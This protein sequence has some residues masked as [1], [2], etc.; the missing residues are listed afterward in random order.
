MATF[1][2]NK[3]LAEAFTSKKKSVIAVKHYSL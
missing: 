2:P 1:S 3:L